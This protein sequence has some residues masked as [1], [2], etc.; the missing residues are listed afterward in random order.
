MIN[1]IDKTKKSYT[2][3]KVEDNLSGMS[4]NITQGSDVGSKPFPFTEEDHKSNEQYH[5]GYIQNNSPL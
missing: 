2:E 4:N 1:Q 5:F 3:K